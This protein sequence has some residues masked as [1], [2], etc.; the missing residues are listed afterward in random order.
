[1]Q[2]SLRAC[3]RIS[4]LTTIDRYPRPFESLNRANRFGS[5]LSLIDYYFR[6]YSCQRANWNGSVRDARNSHI[7]RDA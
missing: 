5:A 7:A 3:F 1:M 6:S 2:I 4:L